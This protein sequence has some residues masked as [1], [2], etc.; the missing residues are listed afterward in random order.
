MIIVTYTNSE[1]AHY[2]PVTMSSSIYCLVIFRLLKS[3]Y[4]YI[5]PHL[6]QRWI[7]CC[8]FIPG[9]ARVGDLFLK[10]SRGQENSISLWVGSDA[11]ATS[12]RHHC[13]NEPPRWFVLQQ[14]WIAVAERDNCFRLHSEPVFRRMYGGVLFPEWS[15]C[16][17]GITISFQHNIGDTLLI[18][19]NRNAGHCKTN[20][21]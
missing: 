20:F 11:Q 7:A 10:L 13:G 19:L 1:E 15:D 5:Y 14:F 8:W 12:L 21:T 18:M 16:F 9:D 4:L 2:I 17:R 3:K 6:S